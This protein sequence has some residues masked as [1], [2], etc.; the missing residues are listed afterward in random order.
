MNY[1]RYGRL[2]WEVS[3]LGF[4]GLRFPLTVNR[5]SRRDEANVDEAEAIR[6]IRYA[7]DQGVNYVDTGSLYHEGRSEV[8]VGK[9]LKDGY[10]QN[11]KLSTKPAIGLINSWQELDKLFSEQL[12]RLQVD[13]VDIY[14]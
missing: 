8:V 4:G 12:T 11:V 2:E 14:C 6:M 1:R 13:H 3:A 10:R 9:A 7:I 5:A